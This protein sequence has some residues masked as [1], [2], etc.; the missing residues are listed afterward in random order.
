MTMENMPSFERADAFLLAL[1]KAIEAAGMNLESYVDPQKGVC[2]NIV[3][4]PEDTITM[5]KEGCGVL[6]VHRFII[7]NGLDKGET[8]KQ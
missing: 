4:G 2:F 8:E 5:V 7:E 6:D 3:R 1:Y